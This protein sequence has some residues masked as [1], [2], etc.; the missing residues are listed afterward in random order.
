MGVNIATYPNAG[1]ALQ[2]DPLRDRKLLIHRR[3]IAQ[4][5]THVKQKG[6]TLIPLAIYFKRGW[7]KCELGVAVGKGRYDKRD[8]LKKRD[9]QR[10]IAREMGRRRRS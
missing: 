8:A 10:E 5:A 7:A 3:Q 4:L 1:P 6:K 9:Q 2:H